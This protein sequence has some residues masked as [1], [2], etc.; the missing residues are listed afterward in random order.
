MP[1]YP[2]SNRSTH[3]YPTPH[4]RVKRL[5]PLIARYPTLKARVEQALRD[6]DKSTALFY[7]RGL[8]Y[9]EVNHG[10]GGDQVPP[11]FESCLFAPV[12]LSSDSDDPLECAV[13]KSVAHSF[14]LSDQEAIGV[15]KYIL[16]HPSAPTELP[17]AIKLEDESDGEGAE[18]TSLVF[19]SHD[20]LILVLQGGLA[21]TDLARLECTSKVFSDAFTRL[22]CIA[23][24]RLE[25]RLHYVC[26]SSQSLNDK[27]MAYAFQHLKC[28]SGIDSP[29]TF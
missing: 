13:L 15:E 9:F 12:D 26:E 17:M 19:L 23:G 24:I 14:S 11:S 20:V 1:T 21:A 8:Q 16:D 4:R 7:L 6:D 5:A 28:R 29:Q 18:A 2:L 25:E 22:Q 10:I 27:L 3:H